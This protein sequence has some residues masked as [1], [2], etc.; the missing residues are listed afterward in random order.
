MNE[1]IWR[2]DHSQDIGDTLVAYT[3]GGRLLLMDRAWFNHKVPPRFITPAII[4]DI[5]AMLQE[6]AQ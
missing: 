1:L 4:A 2:R 5:K 6:H 3:A